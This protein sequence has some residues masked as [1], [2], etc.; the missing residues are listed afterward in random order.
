MIRSV[1]P[2]TG[3]GDAPTGVDVAD[4]TLSSFGEDASGR[5]HVVQLSGAVSRLVDGMASPCLPTPVNTPPSL[6]PGPV[7]GPVD[8]LPAVPDLNFDADGDGLGAGTDRCPAAA[9][10]TSDGCRVFVRLSVTTPQRSA[11]TKRVSVRRITS[12]VSGRLS[13]TGRLRHRTRPTSV[14]LSR[15]TLS[16]IAGRTR[17]GSLALSAPVRRI[18]TRRLRSGRVEID[19][20]AMLAGARDTARVR[21][22]AR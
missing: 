10:R 20:S 5:V 7:P 11:L 4:F 17:A 14:R 2:S 6:P 1:V 15:V 8:G 19:L 18:V 3:A 13:L 16:V 9:H 22:R 21:I 12:N